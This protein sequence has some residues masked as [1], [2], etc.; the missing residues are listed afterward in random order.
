MSG[1]A[2]IEICDVSGEPR[3]GTWNRDGVIL[4]EPHWREGLHRVSAEGG[5]PEPVTRIDEKRRETTHRWPFFLP[6]GR[7]YLYLVASHVAEA[8]S[9]ENAIY[10][11]ELGSTDR[12]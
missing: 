9:G 5:T 2:A 3:G 6:D 11:G 1:G 12:A 7:H 8:T 4:F 10:L